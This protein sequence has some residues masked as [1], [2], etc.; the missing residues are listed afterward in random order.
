[1]TRCRSAGPPHRT[2]VRATIRAGSDPLA[3]EIV[4]ATSRLAVPPFTTAGAALKERIRERTCHRRAGQGLGGNKRFN[5]SHGNLM[6]HGQRRPA[7]HDFS[8]CQQQSRGWPAFAGHDTETYDVTA[9]D[10]V[11]SP[12]A[13]SG[14]LEVRAGIEPTFADLQSAASPLCHRTPWP[15]ASRI[16]CAARPPVKPGSTGSG[17]WSAVIDLQS[18][19]AGQWSA[20]TGRWPAVGGR[21]RSVPTTDRREPTSNDRPVCRCA[22]PD[23]G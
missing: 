8:C 14:K 18:S 10:S 20:V 4:D 12:Q 16:S 6:C 9:I 7:T 22:Q 19:A 15:R 3:L 5:R 13:L 1:M 23:G 2:T 11:V 21:C 17:Q